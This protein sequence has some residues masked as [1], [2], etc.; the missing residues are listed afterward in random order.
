[1]KKID[2]FGI[3]N[4]L[5][6]I[7][8]QVEDQELTSLEVQKGIMHLVD[9]QRQT[10]VLNQ[11]LDREH[12]IE[13][14]GSGLNAIRAVAGMGGSVGFAGQIGKDKFGKKIRERM[15]EL[16]IEALLQE[17]DEDTGSCAVL[18][19]PDGERTMNTNLGASRL[20]D[21]TLV[22]L[23][24]IADAKVLHITGYQWDTDGQ[25]RAMYKAIE[26]AKENDTRISFDVADPFV[27]SRHRQELLNLIEKHADIVFA[28]TEEAKML[29]NEDARYACKK[30]A[31][32]GAIAVIKCGGEGALIA[33]NEELIKVPAKTVNVIDT[34]AAGDVFAGGFLFSYTQGKSLEQCGQ[35]ATMLAGDVITRVGTTVSNEVLS[36][37][38][39]M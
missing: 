11:F 7:I 32:T 12:T 6:D 29:Y 20:F 3:C 9:S 30:I 17:A 21:E 23:Q 27:V 25:K 14:G 4:A 1:M 13:L 15:T 38:A 18:V 8:V 5:V 16:K 24:L 35:A 34:T 33:K 37:A 39:V 10:Q 36:A 26:A 28:N 22:P 19:S 2:V 31:Q